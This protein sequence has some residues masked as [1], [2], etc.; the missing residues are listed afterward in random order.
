MN[1]ELQAW[2]VPIMTTIL[3]IVIP[4]VINLAKKATW[5]ANTKRWVAICFSVVGG[6]TT[7]FI[8]GMPSTPELFVGWVLTVVGG[9]QVVYAAFKSIGITSNWLDALEGIGNKPSEPTE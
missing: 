2:V 3:T 6:V 5:S 9:V 8:A 7:G 4:F 1:M